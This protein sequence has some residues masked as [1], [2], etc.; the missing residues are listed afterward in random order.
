MGEPE[1]A[2]VAAL[3]ARALRCRDDAGELAAVREEVR[4][5]RK[6]FD[7]Y[8]DGAGGLL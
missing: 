4:A 1:M 3:L 8:P 2:V 6:V 7:P 5:L